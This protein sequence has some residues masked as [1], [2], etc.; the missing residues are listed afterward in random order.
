MDI[1]IKKTKALEYVVVD[2]FY[3]EEELTSIKNELP[4]LYAQST[5]GTTASATENGM[6]LKSNNSVF[7]DGVYDKNR[8]ASNILTINRKIFD[9]HLVATLKQT[10]SSYGHIQKCSY[11]STM[12]NFYSG[13]DVYKS[14]TDS[15]IFTFITMLRLADFTGGAL[16]FADYDENV[17]FKDNRLVI[18]PGCVQHESLPFSGFKQYT[19]VTLAQFLNYKLGE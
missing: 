9:P 4:F 10:N 15:S 18:F 11:D 16:R 1:Q 17:E 14:H 2:N 8:W 6:L 7:L 13:Q 5:R 3:T 19:R 12:V